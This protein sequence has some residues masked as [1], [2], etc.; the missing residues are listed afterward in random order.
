[1]ALGN[2]MRFTVAQAAVV[3]SISTAVT[4]MSIEARA[5]ESAA[6]PAAEVGHVADAGLREPFGVPGGNVEPGGL[7]QPGLREEH[8]PGEFAELGFGLGAEPG[9]GEDRGDQGGGV[10]G[11]AERVIELGTHRPRGTGPGTPAAPSLR[12]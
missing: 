8:A 7:F 4:V 12:S 5:S 10:A 6:E 2:G 9:L 1:M 3:S 11:L